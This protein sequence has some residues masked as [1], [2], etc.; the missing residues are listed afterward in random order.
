MHWAAK[1][2]SVEILEL[3]FEF[4]APLDVKAAQEP[5]MLPIHWAAADGKLDSIA[6]LLSKGQDINTQDSNGCSPVIIAVQYNQPDVVIYFHKHGADLTMVDF[7]GDHALHWA[8]YKGY[9][10]ILQIV[11]YFHPR[12]LNTTDKFGQVSLLS[13]QFS[14]YC[15]QL[16]Y[17]RLY[18]DRRR[19]I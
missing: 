14:L 8:A 4:G 13:L 16:N 6:F 12:E 15:I 19:C 2:G 18:Y 3:L 9:D 11:L 10:E 1:R 7:N 17:F 5:N